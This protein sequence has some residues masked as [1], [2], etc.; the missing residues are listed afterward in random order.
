ME[1]QHTPILTS[2]DHVENLS[3]GH[4]I[5]VQVET[6][7]K[8]TKAIDGQAGVCQPPPHPESTNFQSSRAYVV[9]APALLSTH[10]E[11]GSKGY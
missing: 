2:S 7:S 11:L 6:E 10:H 5:S 3:T 9:S 1:N 4:Q 8:L